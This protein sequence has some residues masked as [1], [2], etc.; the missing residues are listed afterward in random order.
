V[1]LIIALLIDLIT[2]PFTAWPIARLGHAVRE[3][4]VSIRAS[5]WYVT[6]GTVVALHAKEDGRLWY[7]RVAYHYTAESRRFIG[8]WRRVLVF[9]RD[10]DKLMGK[11]PRGSQITLRYRP[12]RISQSIVLDADQP[13]AI[14]EGQLSPSQIQDVGSL[15]QR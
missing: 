15:D 2:R 4:W 10:V 1:Q 7:V 11:H 5:E 8:V 9:G 6:A 3:L 12:G 14:H 13:P